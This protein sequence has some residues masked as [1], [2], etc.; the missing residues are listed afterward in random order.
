LLCRE[1]LQLNHGKMEIQSEPNK[2]TVF[3]IAFPTPNP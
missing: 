1:L 2:G 3:T